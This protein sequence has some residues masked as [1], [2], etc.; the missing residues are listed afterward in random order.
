MAVLLFHGDAAVSGALEERSV[1]VQRAAMLGIWRMSLRFGV[2]PRVALL[3]AELHRLFR[4]EG[5]DGVLGWS[6]ES[7]NAIYWNCLGEPPVREDHQAKLVARFASGES[8]RKHAIAPL[9]RGISGVTGG[10]EGSAAGGGGGK[11]AQQ[12]TEGSRAGLGRQTRAVAKAASAT[13]A[14]GAGS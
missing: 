6:T 9:G 1:G 10:A 12:S 14:S 4:T 11:P 2:V 8:I 13:G 3:P 5:D 7:V